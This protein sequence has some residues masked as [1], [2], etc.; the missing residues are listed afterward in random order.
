MV[1][2]QDKHDKKK[3]RQ[4]AFPQGASLLGPQPQ[5]DDTNEDGRQPEKHQ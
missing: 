3:P 1:N 5:D 2:G 4:N